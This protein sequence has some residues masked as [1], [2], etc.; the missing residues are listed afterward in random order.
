MSEQNVLSSLLMDRSEPLGNSQDN[1]GRRALHVKNMTQLITVP[2]DAG[3][4]EYPDSITEVYKYRTGGT[5]GTI[6]G[7]ITLVYTNSS[8]KLL[9]SWAKT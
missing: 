9:A 6:V 2:F 3:T 1:D 8:K 4:V 7:T 5:G